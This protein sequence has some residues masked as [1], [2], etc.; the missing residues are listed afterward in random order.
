MEQIRW[1]LTAKKDYNHVLLFYLCIY[2]L[3][4][5]IQAQKTI[6]NQLSRNWLNDIYTT[7]R[8]RTFAR[9]KVQNITLMNHLLRYFSLSCLSWETELGGVYFGK[10][11]KFKP[12][13]WAKKEARSRDIASGKHILKTTIQKLL[14][15]LCS[16]R[17]ILIEMC[18]M[19]KVRRWWIPFEIRQVLAVTDEQVI[20][21]FFLEQVRQ[22]HSST[23]D[24]WKSG[25]GW[26]GNSNHNPIIG[27]HV[28]KRPIRLCCYHARKKECL[29]RSQRKRTR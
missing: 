6:R 10:F 5:D 29:D 16:A 8:I 1:S 25:L 9:W 2:L 14:V 27:S 24:A 12:V 23:L 17:I 22:V 19:R 3:H 20:V 15:V 28:R 11:R 18:R 7:R 13:L 21:L 4:A 26:V